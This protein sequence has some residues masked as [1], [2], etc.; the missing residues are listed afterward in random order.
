VVI[1]GTIGNCLLRK[2]KGKYVEREA[3]GCYESSLS[4]AI[5]Q[6][7]VIDYNF[8]NN[9]SEITQLDI[10]FFRLQRGHRFEGNL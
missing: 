8:T 9:L 10:D 7:R 6:Q 5:L 2:A 1:L 4:E 3:V